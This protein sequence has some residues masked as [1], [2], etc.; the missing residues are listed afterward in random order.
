[1]VKKGA[2]RRYGFGE[3]CAELGGAAGE[4]GDAGLFVAGD[5]LRQYL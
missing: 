3:Q 5:D 1:M 4:L 2:G